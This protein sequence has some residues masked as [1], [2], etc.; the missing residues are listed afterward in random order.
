MIITEVG[1][2]YLEIWVCRQGIWGPNVDRICFSPPV[3]LL[4]PNV[5]VIKNKNAFFLFIIFIIYFRL[6]LYG[7]CVMRNHQ[8]EG[9]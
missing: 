5:F 9:D 7:P 2:V 4:E 6:C 1:M 3:P 8:Q